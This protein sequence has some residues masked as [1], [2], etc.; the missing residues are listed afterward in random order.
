MQDLVDR[1]ATP[2]AAAVTVAKKHWRDMPSK[3]YGGAVQWLKRYQREFGNKVSRHKDL[4]EFKKRHPKW[5]IAFTDE[6]L[7]KS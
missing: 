5:D 7:S 2:N 6:D 1:G 4:L 3:S